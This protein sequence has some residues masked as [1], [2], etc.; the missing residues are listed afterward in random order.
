MQTPSEVSW[1]RMSYK[2]R[3]SFPWSHS[4][5][6]WMRKLEQYFG[7]SKFSRSMP[8]NSPKFAAKEGLIIQYLILYELSLVCILLYEVPFQSWLACIIRKRNFNSEKF[9][10]DEKLPMNFFETFPECSPLSI[11][12]KKK[13]TI[14]MIGHHSRLRDM[15]SQS[16][17]IYACSRANHAHY[18][19]VHVQFCS[20]SKRTLIQ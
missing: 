5:I 14:K 7:T 16:S 1:K 3:E 12:S 18:S 4:V 6:E 11:V 2:P 8:I 15:M 20:S 17:P 13:K 9:S 10:S 19:S